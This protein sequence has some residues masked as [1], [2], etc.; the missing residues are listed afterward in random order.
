[1]A[2]FGRIGYYSRAM[3]GRPPSDRPR[4]WAENRIDEV[5]QR[6]GL[7]YQVI[8]NALPEA[9]DGTPVSAST[10]QKLA[11]GVNQLTLEWMLKLAAAMGVRASEFI[12]EPPAA[13]ALPSEATIQTILKVVL[14]SERA[15]LDN[16]D[17]LR[18]YGRLVRIALDDVASG[19]VA[20]DRQDLIEYG[21]RRS[22]EEAFRA[23]YAQVG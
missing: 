21:L 6:L 23:K 19:R 12:E 16:E 4:Q 5:R 11:K 2:G 1:M 10:V 22:I 14:S 8:A 18:A 3:A 9:D 7:S 17:D 15:T 20:E 13:P